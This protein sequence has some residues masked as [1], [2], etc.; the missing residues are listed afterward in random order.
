MRGR[1]HGI[2]TGAIRNKTETEK[3]KKKRAQHLNIKYQ[4]GSFEDRSQEERQI[5]A[6]DQRMLQAAP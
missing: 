6:T 5:E 4:R 1:K 2:G 3:F